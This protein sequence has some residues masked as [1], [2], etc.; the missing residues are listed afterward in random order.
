ML[1][2]ASR[3]G[4]RKAAERLPDYWAKKTWLPERSTD[5]NSIISRLKEEDSTSE[6]SESRNNIP[7]SD[8]DIA[9]YLAASTVTHCMDGWSYLGQAISAELSGD[10]EL[11]G[12]LGYYAELRAVM[13]VLAGDGIGVFNNRHVIIDEKAACRI[14]PQGGGTHG[15]AWDGFEFWADTSAAVRTLQE[16]IYPGGIPLKEWLK[17]FPG[18]NNADFIAT[19]WLKKWGLDLSRLAKDR[20]ARNLAS[21]RPTIFTSPGPTDIEESLD[22]ITGMWE[23]CAPEVSG[24]FPALD[25]YL[26]R[27]I[28][29]IL[30]NSANELKRRQDKNHFLRDIRIMMHGIAP[31]DKPEDWWLEFLTFQK[32]DETPSIFHYAAGTA[33]P[34]D[35]KHSKEVLARATLLLRLASGSASELFSTSISPGGSELEFWWS[36][37]SVRRRLWEKDQPPQAFSDLWT[38]VEEAIDGLLSWR[39]EAASTTHMHLWKDRAREAVSLTTMERT[40][41][42]GLRL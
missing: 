9:D 4:V 28:V 29:E 39:E 21:Y 25:R 34:T 6:T 36:S 14:V 22:I 11:A 27:Y 31:L 35:P 38:D 37:D 17:H 2:Q 3:I 20:N 7:S 41:L 33:R 5:A 40:A 42:W 19:A 23:I 12:H 15:F 13:S 16:C 24:G 8:T 26:L 30:F 32:N 10:P 1:R 18:T